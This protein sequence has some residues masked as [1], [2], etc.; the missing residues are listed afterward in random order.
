MGFWEETNPEEMSNRTP[1]TIVTKHHRKHAK[2]AVFGTGH[3]E[4]FHLNNWRGNRPG[5]PLVGF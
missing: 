2:I 4:E 1:L 5:N 3:L